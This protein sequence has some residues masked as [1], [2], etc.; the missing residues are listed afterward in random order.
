MIAHTLLK[1]NMLIVLTFSIYPHI[2]IYVHSIT[3]CLKLLNEFCNII[4]EIVTI[5]YIVVKLFMQWIS[6]LQ[7]WYKMQDMKSTR[8]GHTYSCFY[9]SKRC[10]NPVVYMED[11]NNAARGY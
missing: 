6:I 3:Y 8:K 7:M 11:I 4:H 2:M 1:V 9:Y 5:S 10:R